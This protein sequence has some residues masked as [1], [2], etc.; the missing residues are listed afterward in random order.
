MSI[1]AYHAS[2]LK[3][4]DH[5][6]NTQK[7]YILKP[8][9][10][11]Y[12]AIMKHQP[13][14]V[15]SPN[16][17][18][19]PCPQIGNTCAVVLR[20]DVGFHADDGLQWPQWLCP[21]EPHLM[22]VL[23]PQR[24]GD[25]ASLWDAGEQRDW[26]EDSS[27]GSGIGMYSRNFLAN[28]DIAFTEIFSKH[29]DNVD[30]AT[31]HSHSTTAPLM[32]GS[33]ETTGTARFLTL[34]HTL[35][36]IGLDVLKTTPLTFNRSHFT[37]RIVQRICI[38]Y[39][40][41]V[42][43]ERSIKKYVRFEAG[44]DLNRTQ[45]ADL[46]F[47]GCFTNDVKLLTALI[48][49]RIPVWS[50]HDIDAVFNK[51]LNICCIGASTDPDNLVDE[52][53]RSSRVR[54]ILY[55]GSQTS[56]AKYR[57]MRDYLFLHMGRFHTSALTGSGSIASRPPLLPPLPSRSTARTTASH[58]RPRKEP[59][60]SRSARLVL[61]VHT[62]LPAPPRAWS[63]ALE[64]IDAHESRC[65]DKSS[66]PNSGYFLP[67]PDL[68][69]SATHE[70]SI[71]L[72]NAWLRIRGFV[73]LAYST[74]TDISILER[75]RLGHQPWRQWLSDI[76]GGTTTQAGSSQDNRRKG[77]IKS[78]VV[79]FM[80]NIQ[81]G[82]DDIQP[83]IS[84]TPPLWHGTPFKPDDALIWREV[85]WELSFLSFRL[86]LQDID[87]RLSTWDEGP[88]H[89]GT[90]L[91]VFCMRG[92]SLLRCDLGM[93]NVGLMDVDW[94]K[95]GQSVWALKTLMNSWDV[96]KPPAI[97]DGPLASG[98]DMSSFAQLEAEVVC[99]FID[100]YWRIYGRAP[101][102]PT[103]LSHTPPPTRCSWSVPKLYIIQQP[104]GLWYP[105]TWVG[106]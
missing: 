92:T 21:E 80:Q 60:P 55:E 61:P 10:L 50:V 78:A 99:F 74:P 45:T 95:R 96:E 28:L 23:R 100:T 56:G 40:A 66:R 22:C 79:E 37:L 46:S 42:T 98:Y 51:Q 67:R 102:L 58:S 20:Q 34:L 62:F 44:P 72:V 68:F 1:S 86:E 2:L 84:S 94:R 39:Q 8:E 93:A 3:S 69:T 14:I 91:D 29:E 101:T 81:E 75:P 15:G 82:N 35:A 7:Q 105:R 73:L 77:N 13:F 65:L 97:T 11:V 103:Q 9:I 17:S 87:R 16:C 5:L 38:E 71:K 83:S 24:D 85:L 41:L 36:A 25:L 57:A 53:H 104:D 27:S 52:Q 49:A 12:V 30:F 88:S 31:V 54:G 48:A 4:S 106:R 89:H 26:R 43:F 18:I 32:A 76:A 47:M 63:A 19:A 33:S 64:S 59:Y 90:L 6:V 70:N